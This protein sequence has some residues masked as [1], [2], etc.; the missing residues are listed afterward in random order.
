MLVLSRK[1]QEGI[2]FV[3]TGIKI[4]IVSIDRGKV[5]VGIECPKDIVV[6]RDELIGQ[7]EEEGKNARND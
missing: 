4:K 1:D 5:R 7:N 2:T 3:G 6:L